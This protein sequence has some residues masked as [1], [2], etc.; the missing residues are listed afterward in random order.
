MELTMLKFIRN[1]FVAGSV[2]LSGIFPAHA[3]DASA[4]ALLATF[5]AAADIEGDT[6]ARAK[7]YPGHEGESCDV[8]LGEDRFPGKFIAAD[9]PLLVVDYYSGCDMP[10]E[11][12]TLGGVVVFEQ[13]GGKYRFV[14]IVPGE[15]AL[16]CAVTSIN[17]RQDALV[18]VARH[19]Y[20]GSEHT[21][22]ATAVVRMSFA[23][24][25][26]GIGIKTDKLLETVGSEN[27]NIFRGVACAEKP[28]QYFQYSTPSAGPRPGTIAVD[29]AYADAEIIKIAC[30]KG[31]PKS[32]GQFFKK[33]QVP[34]G[35]EKK[36]RLLIDLITGKVLPPS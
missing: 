12:Q 6:C 25:G 32:K 34:D 4:P 24:D 31:F 1:F 28:P 5:C 3:Q 10:V 9:N 8:S 33:A 13:A 16:Y 2:F 26:K 15:R 7:G 35:K 21:G 23:R 22:V 20:G 36:G 27:S 11:T 30:D 29:V 17:A 14:G 19:D 18:C